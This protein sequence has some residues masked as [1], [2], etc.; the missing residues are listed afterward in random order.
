MLPVVNYRLKDELRNL[1]VCLY[2]PHEIPENQFTTDNLSNFITDCWWQLEQGEKV[3]RIPFHLTP[4]L[5]DAKRVS[6]D[7][8]RCLHESRKDSQ[9]QNVGEPATEPVKRKGID[10]KFNRERSQRGN[11]RKVSD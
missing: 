1:I 7:M 3:K 4:S 10:W 8:K 11:L 2:N 5:V 9:L 6:E